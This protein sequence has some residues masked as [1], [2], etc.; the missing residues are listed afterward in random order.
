MIQIIAQRGEK[1]TI[2]GY[3]NPIIRGVPSLHATIHRYA[4]ILSQLPAEEHYNLYYTLAH[5]TGADTAQTPVRSSTTFEFQTAIPFDIDGADTDR[6]FEYQA[7]VAEVLDCP[8]THL[9]LINSG[10]GVHI[11]ATLRHPIRSAKYF[12]QERPAYIEILL[13]IAARMQARGLPGEPD[14]K[15]FDAARILR[16]PG[17]INKK[18]GKADKHCVLLHASGEALDLN[19]R[20]VSGLSRLEQ[21][22]ILPPEI[23]RTYPQ[24]D[25]P[26]VVKECRFIQ[27]ALGKPEEVHE[28]HAFDLMSLLVNMPPSE[29]V[30]HEGGE[31]TAYQLVEWVAGRATSST[32][33][34]RGQLKNKWEQAR[35]YGCRKCTTI[36]ETMPE[37]CGACPHFGKI[38]TPL[39]LKSATHIGS[40]ATGYWILNAKG[41]YLSPNYSDVSKLYRQ[42]TNLLVAPP[43]RLF[44]FDG[45]K[46]DEV[47]DLHLKS[48]L[49]RKMIPSEPM[50]E[51]YR[52]EFVHKAMTDA[53]KEPGYTDDLFNNSVRGRLNCRNGVVDIRTGEIL[54]H[55]PEYGFR[56]VLPYDYQEGLASEF[57]LEW[58]DTITESRVELMEALLDIAAYCLWPSMDDH[59]F[60]FLIGDGANG[61]STFLHTIQAVVGEANCSAISVQQLVGNRF[62]P[63]GLDGKLVNLSEESS[64]AEFSHE[65]LNVLKTLSSGG[66]I[67]VERKGMEPFTLTNKAKL[68]FSANKA[69]RLGEFGEAV[70]RR[71]IVI[72]FNYTIHNKNPLI[73][74][75]L[76]AEAPRIL[77]MLVAR[78]CSNIKEHGGRFVLSR[79]GA[80]SEEARK[81][82]VTSGNTVVEWARERIDS[83]AEYYE[84]DK[85]YT[86][87]VYQDYKNWC[88]E[89]GV[90]YPTNK[91]NFGRTLVQFVLSPCSEVTTVRDGT[92][93]KRA[94][95]RTRYKN[96]ER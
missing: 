72:P 38:P 16:L 34:A 11:L 19:L 14:R 60:V 36:A 52:T 48:W 22:N 17:T 73:E 18:V 30:P 51:R 31:L 49:E 47:Y 21:E 92:K 78:V 57:F 71:F 10:N 77:S 76:R 58:L 45:A 24:P 8:H 74:E 89:S 82:V 42:E 81:K 64:G 12:A 56:Y 29:K 96:E 3:T 54:P 2:W 65:Q 95:T 6:A 80:A 20:E 7:V 84:T 86:D 62:A 79:G 59:N 68:I 26:T 40:A 5:H 32:S 91:I 66:D 53:A 27:W 33:L 93:V 37:I 9:T 88:A 61:K 94:Y 70:K 25:F 1:G 46:Y 44:V 41:D 43:K 63:A 4:E 50:R 39:A 55:S 90:R 23:R 75:R 13:K 15:V 85:V 67:Q 28:P 35:K 83:R 69:P 87:E